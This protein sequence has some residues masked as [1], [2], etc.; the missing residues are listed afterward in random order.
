MITLWGQDIF[1]CKLN[2]LYKDFPNLM[3]IADGILVCG[4][5]ESE[6]DQAFCKMPEATRKH[7]VRPEI[8]S[9]GTKRLL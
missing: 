7:N 1:Q 9:S 2:K 4:S 3:G 8:C 5:T 6:Y